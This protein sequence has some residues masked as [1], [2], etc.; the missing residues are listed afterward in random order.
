MSVRIYVPSTLSM[1]AEVV[2]SGGVGPVPVLAHA[3][4]EAVR[5]GY[6]G[7]GEEEWEYAAMSAAAQD[8][9]ALLTEE[10]VPRR[11]VIALDTSAVLPVEAAEE[12]L[13]EV[14]EVMPAADIAAVHVDSAD[15]EAD[16]SAARGA[17]LDAQN[18]D[19][20][21]VKTVER[22]LDHELGWFATQEIGDLLEE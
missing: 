14:H 4:T 5:A 10:D 6:P 19:A 18:G 9:L 17:W 15:A 8:S 13:V 3:V 16:V 2:V 7:A 21:A 12:S 20:Q 11:V 1:L 22:C